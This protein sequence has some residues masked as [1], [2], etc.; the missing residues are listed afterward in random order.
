MHEFLNTLVSKDFLIGGVFGGVV[1]IFLAQLMTKAG[2]ATAS[3]ISK[4]W[5]ERSAER[6][7][8]RDSRIKR[9][10]GNP[11]LQFHEV[12]YSIIILIY[13][14]CMFEIAILF[15]VTENGTIFNFL[16]KACCGIFSM[17]FLILGLLTMT[18]GSDR[19]LSAR[20]AKLKELEN[21]I[22]NESK[23]A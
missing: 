16:P 4:A 20:E 17:I 21:Q 7:A 15:C 11:S 5:G 13:A 2:D 3:R 10:I 23:K 18:Q 19:Y 22:G 6:K 1:A 9:M 8:E 14:T 12:L